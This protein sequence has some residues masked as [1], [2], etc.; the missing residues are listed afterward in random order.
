MFWEIISFSSF[1]EFGFAVIFGF[2]TALGFG[3]F[4]DF[5]SSPSSN[6]LSASLLLEKD[7][8]SSSTGK[9]L[10][11]L[12]RFKGLASSSEIGASSFKGFLRFWTF[13]FILN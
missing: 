3:D 6:I 9:T 1:S 4:D 13:F 12:S 2:F 10:V 7:D 11:F 8:S 5:D